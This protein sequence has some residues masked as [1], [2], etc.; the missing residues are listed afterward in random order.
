MSG[1]DEGQRDSRTGNPTG[2]Q[3]FF[4]GISGQSSESI[5]ILPPKALLD[6]GAVNGVMSTQQFFLHDELL[7]ALNLGALPTTP[8]SGRW[9]WSANKNNIISTKNR[10]IGRSVGSCDLCRTNSNTLANGPLPFIRALDWTV[11]VLALKDVVES[12]TCMPDMRQ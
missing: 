2:A 10:W 7:R 1:H 5:T 3:S 11:S 9:H 4:C 6:I 12:S 8:P